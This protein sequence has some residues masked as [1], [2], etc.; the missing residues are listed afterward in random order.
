MTTH[1]HKA[2]LSQT[3]RELPLPDQLDPISCTCLHCRSPE[4]LEGPAMYAVHDTLPPDTL[5]ACGN[6]GTIGFL[7][8]CWPAVAAGCHHGI[9]RPWPFASSTPAKGC[10]MFSLPLVASEQKRGSRGSSSSR[11]R[12]TLWCF[13]SQ[14]GCARCSCVQG[15]TE[16]DSTPAFNTIKF[17]AVHQHQG[18][19]AGRTRGGFLIEIADA[20]HGHTTGSVAASWDQ[21]THRGVL[22][23]GSG[24]QVHSMLQVTGQTVEGQ[25]QLP[26]RVSQPQSV[27]RQVEL[28]LDCRD[29]EMADGAQLTW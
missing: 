9:V 10:Q 7:A 8:Q 26:Q 20:A 15:T 13:N 12:A 16:P 27:P 1:R 4:R 28:W 11:G 19:A 3:G 24:A 2:G 23:V 17:A 25:P 18:H 5:Q 14:L 22:A 21:H 29:F 6:A